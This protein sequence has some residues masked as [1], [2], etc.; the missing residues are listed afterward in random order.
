MDEKVMDYEQQV[1]Q[2]EKEKAQVR[3]EYDQVKRQ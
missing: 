2:L 3:I 1:T